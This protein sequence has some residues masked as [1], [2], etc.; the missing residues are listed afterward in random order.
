ME[1]KFS[2]YS[3]NADA[4]DKYGVWIKSEAQAFGLPENGGPGSRFQK[5]TPASDI[6]DDIENMELLAE[7]ERVPLEEAGFSD[8]LLPVIA[9]PIADAPDEAIPD[10]PDTEAESAGFAPKEDEFMKIPMPDEPN[11]ESSF[12]SADNAV[13]LLTNILEELSSIRKELTEVKGLVAGRIA[14]EPLR[15][16]AVS[17]SQ[18]DI[19]EKIELAGDELDGIFSPADFTENPET[20]QFRPPDSG[21]ALTPA[22][23]SAEPDSLQPPREPV[24]RETPKESKAGNFSLDELLIETGSIRDIPIDLNQEESD[25]LFEEIDFEPEFQ[26]I[27]HQE[28]ADQ[29]IADREPDPDMEILEPAGEE[30]FG[31]SDLDLNDVIFPEDEMDISDEELDRLERNILLEFSEKL[32]VIEEIFG[33]DEQNGKTSDTN[34]RKKKMFRR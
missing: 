34:P 3:D 13:R 33:H 30:I 9:I 31:L 29:K 5:K 16:D 20:P 8:E 17:D 18:K 14:P 24:L 6:F 27:E 22:E 12:P 7:A 10:A 23:N 25:D 4:L 21:A 32:P 28:Q 26:R 11:P 15:A 1:K 19:P 2:A